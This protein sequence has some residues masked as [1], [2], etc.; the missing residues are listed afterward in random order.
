MGGT[1]IP[2]LWSGDLPATLEFYRALGYRV[3]SEKTRPYN[4]GIVTRDGYEVHF[5][6]SPKPIDEKSVA[7]VACLVYLDEVEDLHREFTTALRA[8]YGRVPVQGVP[9]ITRFRPGQSRFTVVDPVGNSILYIRRDE[10]DIE[11]GGSKSL[12]GL[13]RVIDNA[14]TLRDFK[15]DDRA[16]SR[17]LESGLRRFGAQ[18]TPVDR[19]R[20]MAMLAEVALATG[21]S[22]RA[23][24]LRGQITD[25]AL[26]DADQAVVA[27]ELRAVTDLAAWLRE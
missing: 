25:L 17:A 7:Y 19:A 10:S 14:R 18:A 23:A 6:P 11:Y 5:G 26:T 22:A 15:N 2:V 21:D 13:Q 27:A 9:R 1:S 16:T 4:Y 3:V 24:E 8:R 12:T 20:A